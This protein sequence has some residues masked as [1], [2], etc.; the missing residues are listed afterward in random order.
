[1]VPSSGSSERNLPAGTPHVSK[2]YVKAPGHWVHIG[3]NQKRE[4]MWHAHS[5]I[6]ALFGRRS[7]VARTIGRVKIAE[8]EKRLLLC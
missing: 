5:L 1:M 8:T 4:I 6:F 2:L 3:A 7:I